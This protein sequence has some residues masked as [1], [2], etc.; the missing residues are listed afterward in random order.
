MILHG[1]DD[2]DIE[3]GTQET[4]HAP[5]AAALDQVFLDAAAQLRDEPEFSEVEALAAKLKLR[6]RYL[7]T[8]RLYLAK[9]KEHPVFARWRELAAGGRV[10]NF[11][12]GLAA[13][14]GIDPAAQAGSITPLRPVAEESG[15]AETGT[16]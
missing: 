16:A 5:N 9:N 7:L 11:E 13:V 12:A 2:P 8:C 14:F 1:Q 3:E 6:P 4:A 15:A 10:A